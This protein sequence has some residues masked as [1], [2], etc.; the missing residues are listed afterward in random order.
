M[1]AIAN[2]LIENEP[3]G[4]GQF[5]QVHRCHNK[6]NANVHYEVKVI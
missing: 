1:K 5:G 4:K 2:Y 3:L 6:D